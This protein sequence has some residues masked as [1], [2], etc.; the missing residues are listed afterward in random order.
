MN[1]QNNVFLNKKDLWLI[2]SY[3][4]LTDVVAIGYYGRSGSVFLQSLLDNHPNILMLPGTLLL[5][6]PDFWSVYAHLPLQELISEFCNYFSPF[7]KINSLAQGGAWKDA[8]IYLN[9][10]KLGKNKD[11]TV[12]V[13][14]DKFVQVLELI[15]KNTI[16]T[17]KSFFQA[18][19]VAYTVAL[20]RSQYLDDTRLPLIVH[21]LHSLNATY[22]DTA[23]LRIH[24]LEKDFPN[25]KIIQMIRE[26]AQALGSHFK[27]HHD[28]NVFQASFYDAFLKTSCPSITVRLEDL[29]TCAEITLRKLAKWLE[30]DWNDSLLTSTFNGKQWWNVKDS[31]Q[32]SGFNSIIISQEH[33]DILSAF[34]KIRLKILYA[35]RYHLWEY[36]KI[37]PSKWK[38][39]AI[40][41]LLL[42]PFRMELIV[43]KDLYKTKQFSVTALF[44]DWKKRRS[45][46]F[47]VW[48]YSLSP[49]TNE[50]PLLTD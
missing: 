35:K 3:S 7:F 45:L 15:L 23:D 17:R 27:H 37:K 2:D 5:I 48:Q 21:Q 11:Q 24:S 46:L 13:N 49:K 10:H 20:N 38:S 8:M 47:K 29:H 19:H 32:V 40:T 44:K 30:I 14:K 9:L 22:K 43:Y 12:E 36:R 18:I 25:L 42:L 6:F 28:I 16:L 50:T 4:A 39:L 34:D 26:P 1:K 41:P 31:A 33:R